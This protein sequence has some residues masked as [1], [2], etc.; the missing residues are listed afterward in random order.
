MS[1]SPTE[2]LPIFLFLK[3][4]AI[5][6]R[7][8]PKFTSLGSRPLMLRFPTQRRKASRSLFVAIESGHS[9]PQ[10]P[11]AIVPAARVSYHHCGTGSRDEIF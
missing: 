6:Q 3:L 8:F 11:P 4:G 10:S 2:T 7:I 5:W 1:P 9:P